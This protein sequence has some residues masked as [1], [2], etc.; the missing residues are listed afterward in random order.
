MILALLFLWGLL[1]PQLRAED[2]PSK[3]S[4]SV[5][6]GDLRESKDHNKA[7]MAKAREFIW[8]HWLERKC[9][10]LIVTAWSKEGV[11]TDSRDKIQLLDGNVPVL[12]T[13]LSRSDGSSSGYEGYEIERIKTEVPYFPDQ[14]KAI[15]D[16]ET[17][18]PSEYRLR[19]RD[20]VGKIITDF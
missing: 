4:L 9:G 10:D 13:T 17:V 12:K 7:D 18:P 19:F 5:K 6:I 8:R 14:A 20:K 3:E 11:R 15:P 16:D 1:I 2:T